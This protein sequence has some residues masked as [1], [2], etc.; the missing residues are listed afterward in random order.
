M[1][2]SYGACRCSRHTKQVVHAQSNPNQ[3]FWSNSALTSDQNGAVEL[4]TPGTGTNSI[5][6]AQPYI[7]FHYGNGQAQDYNV[8]LINSGDGVL[9][10]IQNGSQVFASKSNGVEVDR[11]VNNTGTGIKHARAGRCDAGSGSNDCNVTV[12]WAGAPFADTNYT[13]VCT[14][15]HARNGTLSI[16]TKA[17][18][19]GNSCG[20]GQM[21]GVE[22]IA[23]HD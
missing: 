16:L 4:G 11:G 2:R 7:D 10:V 14:P 6:G 8:R 9:S 23:M 19:T 12:T 20:D 13:A 17:T 18:C 21:S 15:D 22:C 1:R 5:N 3:I